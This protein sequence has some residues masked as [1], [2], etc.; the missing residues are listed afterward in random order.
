MSS[1]KEKLPV[2]IIQFQSVCVWKTQPSSSSSKTG[3]KVINNELCAICRSD[4]SDFCV[5][6]ATM[7]AHGPMQLLPSQRQQQR[8]QEQPVDDK[9]ND[10]DTTSTSSAT[11][12]IKCHVATGSCGHA[13]HKHCVS[14]WLRSHSVCPLCQDPWE[15][16]G[17]DVD[18]SALM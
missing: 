3:G 8:Q 12:I 14:G 17:G 13:F 15:Q 10:D 1:E 9:K 2:E 16:V 18:R 7:A 4:L 5:E 6:C 11:S